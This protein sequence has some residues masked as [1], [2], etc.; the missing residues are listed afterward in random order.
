[1]ASSV[2]GKSSI[3][4]RLA[5]RVRDG[6]A[7]QHAA[8]D[9]FE[10]SFATI[11][12]PKTHLLP[13]GDAQTELR[14]VAGLE[15]S[16]IP[17]EEFRVDS[18][19]YR[20]YFAKAQYPPDYYSNNIVEKSLEHYIAARLLDLSPSDTYIDIASEHS[21]VPEIY[22][23]VF[24]VTAYRQDLSYAPGVRG[25]CIGGDAA[26]MPVPSGFADKMALHCSFE[27]FENN[28]DT[29]FIYEIGRVLRPGGAVCFVPFYLS[30]SYFILTDPEVSAGGDVK[31]EDGVMVRA[32]RNWGNRFGRFYDPTHADSRLWAHLEGLNAR[33]FRLVGVEAVDPSCYARFA[34]LIT[35]PQ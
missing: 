1:M 8:P 19:A 25:D 15:H 23:R 11:R 21:P 17:V 12:P 27:H 32:Y 10:R 35:K 13:E 34:L 18:T 14:I 29:E 6:L 7:P 30:D 3:V 24:G 31:F 9:S 16:S 5:R 20:S 28:S 2:T 22:Q 4:R 33:V 26:H